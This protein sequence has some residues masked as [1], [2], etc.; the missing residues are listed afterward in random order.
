MNESGD[1]GLGVRMA[2]AA[3]LSAVIV[4]AVTILVG[5]AL[6]HDPQAAPQARSTPLV[7]VSR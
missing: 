2:V 6:I 3:T 4:A 7:L 5:R 1:V